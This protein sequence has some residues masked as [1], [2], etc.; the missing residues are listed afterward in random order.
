MSQKTI[1]EL[2]LFSSFSDAPRSGLAGI[3]G[4]VNLA[5][6]FIEKCLQ[7]LFIATSECAGAEGC[8]WTTG[9]SA[10]DGYVSGAL[11]YYQVRLSHVSV[12]PTLEYRAIPVEI[13]TAPLE[14]FANC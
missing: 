2:T 8:L 12:S 7:P 11:G 14:D 4:H 9:T 3:L 13:R 6:M 1:K 10:L 5:E